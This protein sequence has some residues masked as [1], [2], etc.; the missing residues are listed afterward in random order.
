M[1]G[2]GRARGSIKVLGKERGETIM[3]MISL[4]GGRP[5]PELGS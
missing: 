2:G 5:T 1:V 4:V 3:E